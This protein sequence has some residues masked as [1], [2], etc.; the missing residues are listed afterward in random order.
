MTNQEKAAIVLMALDEEA[1][2]RIVRNLEPDEIKTLGL[3]M[4]RLRNLTQEEIQHAASDFCILA[5]EYGKTAI[6]SGGGNIRNILIKAVGEERAEKV[7]QGIQSQTFEPSVNPVIEKL[8]NIEPQIILDFTK[9]EHPQTIAL[10]LAHLRPEQTARI[11]ENLSD[12]MRVEV[13]RRIATLQSVPHDFIDEMAKTL[14][15]ELIT[16]STGEQYFGG[17]DMVADILNKMSRANESAILEMLDESHPDLA[18]DIRNLMFTFDDMLDL[19]DRSMREVLQQVD[20][21]DLARA[22]KVVDED[23]REVFYRNMSK[24]GAEMLKDDIDLMPPTRLSEVEESQK[25]IIEVVKRLEGEGKIQLSR[26]DEGDSF[27]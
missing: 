21:E 18:I 1:A 25:K 10:I 2:A 24:R 22:L 14:E 16:G 13:V 9:S 15:S 5:R 12:E 23:R 17:A 27:V 11:L 6:S 4:N 7:L 26:G 20:G 19:D 8:R 3:H